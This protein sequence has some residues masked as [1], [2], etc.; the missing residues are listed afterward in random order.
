[1][2]YARAQLAKLWLKLLKATVKGKDKKAARL[3][4]KLIEFWSKYE[5]YRIHPEDK[6]FL[7]DNFDKY[8]IDLT[9]TNIFEKYGPD[10]KQDSSHKK[11]LLNNHLKFCD[12]GL[13]IHHLYLSPLLVLLATD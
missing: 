11:F 5:P 13:L 7:G 9:F 1:M 6:R 12:L 3:E 2:S 10:L 4:K 8:C